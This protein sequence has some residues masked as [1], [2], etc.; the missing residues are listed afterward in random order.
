MQALR[1]KEYCNKNPD[2]LCYAL[3]LLVPFKFGKINQD[4]SFN[5]KLDYQALLNQIKFMVKLQGTP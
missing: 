4:F 3:E 1:F 2:Q 5:Q